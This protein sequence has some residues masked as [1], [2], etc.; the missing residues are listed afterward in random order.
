MRSQDE[1]HRRIARNLHDSL[2]QYLA[3]IKMDL[4]L[5]SHSGAQNK[6]EV[7]ATALK[8]VDQSIAETRNVLCLLHPPC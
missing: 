8:S 3:S 1:E 6:D 4:E 5:L 7:L 2:G